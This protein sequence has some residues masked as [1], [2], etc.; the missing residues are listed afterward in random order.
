MSFGFLVLWLFDWSSSGWRSG[1]EQ[2]DIGQMALVFVFFFTPL[3]FFQ[4]N[5]FLSLV[6]H[7]FYDTKFHEFV[8]IQ[9]RYVDSQCSLAYAVKL[10]NF[11]SSWKIEFWWKS[12]YLSFQ[13]KLGWQSFLILCLLVIWRQIWAF[14][15]D[16]LQ[17]SPSFERT[18][19]E[20]HINWRKD[21]KVR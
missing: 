20:E 9:W 19:A 1:G 10:Q 12:K 3:T 13:R 15:S 21:C 6:L 7:F 5:P 17:K 8:K 16:R 2:S 11:I 14:V 4:F 18:E